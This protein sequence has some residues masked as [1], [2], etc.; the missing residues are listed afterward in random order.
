MNLLDHEFGHI[1]QNGSEASHLTQGK[2]ETS[3]CD[4]QDPKW[5]SGT[6]P[7][8]PRPCYSLTPPEPR[9]PSCCSLKMLAMP[10][11]ESLCT[12]C[13]LPL[14]SGE[15]SAPGVSKAGSPLSLKPLP[16]VTFS[17]RALAIIYLKLHPTPV[18]HILLHGFTF[19]YSPKN[20]SLTF[21][22][23][24][25]SSVWSLEC[26]LHMGIS[27]YLPKSWW[28]EG[29]TVSINKSVLFLLLLFNR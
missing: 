1:T 7:L 11:P 23:S 4:L 22:L 19:S 3:Y 25:W 2:N 12:D 24:Q 21:S 26:K 14:S 28:F 20:L 6:S 29:K 13:P 27:R 9:W 5:R 10:P 18:P 17:V 8:W 16:K 15:H